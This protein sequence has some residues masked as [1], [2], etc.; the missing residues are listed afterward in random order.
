[1]TE[2]NASSLPAG[3]L[4]SLDD[5]GRKE[6]WATLA[7][8]HTAGIGARS[9]CTLLKY[10]GSAYSAVLNV[11]AWPE[12]G[13]PQQKAS[14]YL[15]NAW[16]VKARP[17]WDRLRTLPCSIILWTDP[18]YP[19]CLKEL[20][21]APLLLYALGDLSLLSAPCVAIVGSRKSARD[22]LDFTSSTAKKLSEGG[23][24]IVSGLAF[25]VD[26]YAHRA[27][28]SGPGRTIAVMPGGVDMPFPTRHRELYNAVVKYGLAI[29]EM[30]PGWIPGPGAF[31]VRNRI[32]SGLSFG[33]LVSAASHIK[34]GSLITA[35]IAAEQG[36]NVYVPSPDIISSPCEE[37]TKKLL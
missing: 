20:P 24:T 6:Y 31:P 21:D 36:K 22:V 7:L 26:G 5:E 27:A 25:G 29:S 2:L 10:F 19:S 12:A 8:R 17:E 14:G 1:M 15:N 37:G 28:L 33:V 11:H 13:I 18:R 9:A 30:P 3:G 32:I 23:I 34:S 4:S 35:R 16:R